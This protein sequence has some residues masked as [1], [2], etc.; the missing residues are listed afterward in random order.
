MI[1][2]LDIHFSLKQ[3]LLF[4]FGKQ[5]QP[6]SDEFLLN[7]SRSAIM[8]ALKSLHLSIGSRVGV[9]AYNCHTVFSAVRSAGCELVFIDVTDDLH[10]DITDFNNKKDSLSA[11][12][13]THLFGIVNDISTI[14]EVCGDLLIIEDCA[15]AYSYGHKESDFVTYSIG[16]GKLPSIGD[17]GIL[18]VNN[19]DYLSDVETEYNSLIGYSWLD[20]VKLFAKL[21]LK[22]LM[23]R[24]LVYTYVTLPIKQ[25]R[26]GHNS[27]EI[28]K[29]RK[30]ST[31][32]SAIYEYER[33]RVENLIDILR[34]NT[35]LLKDYL[36]KKDD[37]EKVIIG[38]NAFMLVIR[39]DNKKSL[40]EFF[41]SLGIDCATHFGESYAWAVEYGMSK[42]DCPM[43][44]YLC[45]HLLM[46]PTYMNFVGRG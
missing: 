20:N 5:Y 43:V 14:R 22:S 30:M 10:L 26:G 12:V 23:Y 8:L 4:C 7:H 41:F 9:M 35:M 25:H 42:D 13:V 2:R 11:L 24:P 19:Q 32:I 31:C 29:P 37:V 1:P 17:G 40:Q 21:W 36:E 6:T 33:Q 3:K 28:V 15:H 46:L 18:K 39:S 38:Q 44:Q 45:H 16:Q 34:T 27:V